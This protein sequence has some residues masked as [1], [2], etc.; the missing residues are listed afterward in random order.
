MTDQQDR[1]AGKVK[2][3]A[4]KATGDNRLETEG[5]TQHSKGKLKGKLE[6]LRDTIRGVADGVKGERP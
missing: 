2:E 6:N 4:G 5:K 1:L 3:T